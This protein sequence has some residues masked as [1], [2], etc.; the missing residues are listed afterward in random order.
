[1][2]ALRGVPFKVDQSFQISCIK[3]PR[4]IIVRNKIHKKKHHKRYFKICYA[5]SL[6]DLLS[7]ERYSKIV[8]LLH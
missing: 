3:K 6:Y 7:S 1:M 4:N 8:Y 5:N 2:L